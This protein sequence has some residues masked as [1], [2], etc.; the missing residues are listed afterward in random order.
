[1]AIEGQNKVNLNQE[2]K[3]RCNVLDDL[4]RTVPDCFVSPDSYNAGWKFHKFTMI[5]LLWILMSRFYTKL[6]EN[7][8]QG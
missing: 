7:V 4:G 3:R 8:G 5:T 6:F 2:K 1:M